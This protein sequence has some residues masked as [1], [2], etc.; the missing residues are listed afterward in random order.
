MNEE[1]ASSRKPKKRRKRSRRAIKEYTNYLVRL[2]RW[3]YFYSFRASDPK[4]RWERGPYS[5]LTTLRLTGD[6]IRPENSKYGQ[7]EVTL[8]ARAGMMD[9]ARSDQQ[10]SVGSLRAEDE[11]LSAYIFVPEERFAELMIAAQSGRLE[12]VHF[13]STKLRYRSATIL[14]VTLNTDF[15]EAD[16]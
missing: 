2:S 6:L 13:V 1:T 11:Q 4:N 7:I 16:W 10:L 12:V 8:S 5:S 3:D 14:N 9:E 15:D